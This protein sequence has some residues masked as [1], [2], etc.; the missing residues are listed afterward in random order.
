MYN[1]LF[2]IFQNI[3]YILDENIIS[4]KQ[5]YISFFLYTTF[6]VPYHL[7]H[8]IIFIYYFNF[9]ISID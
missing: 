1:I 7:C 9:T 6:S 4:F 3:Y 5:L 8:F 2:I